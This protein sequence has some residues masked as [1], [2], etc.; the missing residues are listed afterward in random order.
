MRLFVGID[1]PETTV[2]ALAEF[3][4]E[5]RRQTCTGRFK[6]QENFHLTLKFLGE[7]AEESLDRLTDALSRV[8]ATHAPFRLGLGDIGQFGNGPTV[9]VVWVGL[10]GDLDRLKALQAGVETAAA[11]V[12]FAPEDRPY[13]PHITV[14]QDVVFS[15]AGWRARLKPTWPDEFAVTEFS[16]ILST[17]E[18]GRRV[19]IP[20]HIFKLQV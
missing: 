4:S 13:R 1:F 7:T 9:R 6:R 14:A 3:Q 2:A 19:Y 15:D 18:Y 5:L 17:Q 11:R 8:A 20:L 12:G 16:L 10:K